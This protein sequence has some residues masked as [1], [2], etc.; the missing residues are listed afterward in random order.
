MNLQYRQEP[1]DSSR[2]MRGTRSPRFRLL[3]HAQKQHTFAEGYEVTTRVPV[4]TSEFPSAL[5]LLPFSCTPTESRRIRVR[6]GRFLCIAQPPISSTRKHLPKSHCHSRTCMLLFFFQHSGSFS[7]LVALC[8]AHRLFGLFCRAVHDVT[9]DREARHQG[10]V[11]GLFGLVACS[12]AVAKAPKS[13]TSVC[14]TFHSLETSP[15]G[16]ACTRANVR[17][18]CSFSNSLVSVSWGLGIVPACTAGHGG[19][20]EKPLHTPTT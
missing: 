11:S 6:H 9:H 15:E 8:L 4:L 12:Y 10:A 5:V 3:M 20:D 19:G 13:S 16:A 2:P 17:R 7:S 18:A 1:E 14:I